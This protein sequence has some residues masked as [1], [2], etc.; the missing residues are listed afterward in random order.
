MNWYVYDLSPVDFGWEKLK[1]VEETAK[2]LGAAEAMMRARGENPAMLDDPLLDDF[3]NNWDSAQGAAQEKGWEGDFRHAPVV[4][5]IPFGGAFQY[6]FAFKQDNNGVTFIVSPK[7][8]H[9]L[10]DE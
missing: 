10:E 9:W 5:W 6:G 4:F 3:L 8:M 2:E 7:P 1:T